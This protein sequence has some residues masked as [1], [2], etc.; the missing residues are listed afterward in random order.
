MFYFCFCADFRE[1][2][3]SAMYQTFCWCLSNV[4]DTAAVASRD[5]LAD[6]ASAVRHFGAAGVCIWSHHYNRVMRIRGEFMRA[7]DSE[8]GASG[9][10]R[11][12]HWLWV[13]AIQRRQ[14][15][16]ETGWA[17]DSG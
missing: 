14:S 3:S 8:S 6:S 16:V 1:L 15:A 17:R 5:G 11:A 10:E 2:Q 12:E 7:S 9:D 4:A 13:C